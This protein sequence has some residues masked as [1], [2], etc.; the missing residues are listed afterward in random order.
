M[1]Y[2]VVYKIFT[3]EH[4]SAIQVALLVHDISII[5]FLA[6]ISWSRRIG[7]RPLLGSKSV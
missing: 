2:G 7:S 3:F 1:A 4:A 5:D 6:L